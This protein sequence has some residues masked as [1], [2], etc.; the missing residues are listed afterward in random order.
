[1]KRTAAIL[2][3]A[4]LVMALVAGCGGASKGPG[5]GGKKEPIKLGAIFDI[6]GGT[7]DVGKPHS[8][9]VRAYIDFINSKGGVNGATIDLKWV[10]YA[11]QTPKAVEAYNKLTKE[12]HVVAVMGWGTGDTEAMKE[13]IAK[14]KIPYISGSYSE[15]L[16]DPA[17][18]PYNFIV[19]P[20]YSQ[21][22]RI[23]LDYAKS[24]KADAKVALVYND[25]GFGKSPLEDA[26]AY[27]KKIGLNWVGEVVVA[28]T[29]TDATTQVLE[30]DKLGAE[31][32]LI[33]E[34][35]NATAVT[36]K[37]AKKQGLSK[38]QFMGLSYSV[39]ENLIKAAGD[40][41]ENFIGVPAFA[42]PYDKG[43]GIDEAVAYAKSKKMKVEDLNQKWMQGWA[44]GRIMCEAIKRAGD[45]PTGESIKAAFETMKEYDLGGLG[46]PLTFTAT[47]HGG[48]KKGLIYKV[49]GGKWDPQTEFVAPKQ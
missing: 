2:W 47:D 46:S 26:K 41:A 16:I 22:S 37:S 35:T 25:S 43:P 32:V 3:V 4:L 36:L 5:G 42:F 45:N 30:L 12:D 1:M 17:K 31:F 19:G 29:A 14:D 8:E 7:G 11:Y 40:A 27:A 21:T 38:M 33:Q 28:L 9:G 24:Q 15:Q 13:L 18:T 49:W 10:D 48:A 23:L 34:T 44:F 6:S 20:T 39:D